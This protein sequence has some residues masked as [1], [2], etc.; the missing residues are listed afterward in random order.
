[1]PGFAGSSQFG[2]DLRAQTLSRVL[3]LHRFAAR[4]KMQELFGEGLEDR[5]SDRVAQIAIKKRDERL[6]R[7]SLLCLSNETYFVTSPRISPPG[8]AAVWTLT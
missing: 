7:S 5:S 4:A 8:L 3:S 1:M 2:R 6:T